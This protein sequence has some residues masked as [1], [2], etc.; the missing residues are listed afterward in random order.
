[1]LS[2]TAIHAVRALSYL[3]TLPAGTFAG[4]G[5]LADRADAPRNYLG[6]LLQGLAVAGVLESRKGAGGGFRLA[7]AAREIS[8]YDVVEPIDRV[9]AWRRCF[10]GRSTCSDDQPCS[11]HR[12]WGDLRDR[13][14]DFL[15]D[16]TIADIAGDHSAPIELA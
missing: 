3:A 2:R 16:T 6:K 15:A 8:L 13:Y 12:N 14:L 9:S 7:R 4:A 11:V 10:L 5:E 1:M